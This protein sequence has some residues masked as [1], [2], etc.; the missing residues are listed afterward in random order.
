MENKGILKKRNQDSRM[1]IWRDISKSNVKCALKTLSLYSTR[2]LLLKLD[3]VV[4]KLVT[5]LS[6]HDGVPSL[7]RRSTNEV[8]LLQAWWYLL[9][10]PSSGWPV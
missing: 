5:V 9:H 10:F 1:N 3:F 4:V 8:L 7:Q 6:G 2:S